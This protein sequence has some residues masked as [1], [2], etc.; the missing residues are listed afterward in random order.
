M[1]TKRILSSF[2]DLD[3]KLLHYSSKSLEIEF[4]KFKEKKYISI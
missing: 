2:I 3:G 4:S 1:E